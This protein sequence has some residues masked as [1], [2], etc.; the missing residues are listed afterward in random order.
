MSYVRC[1]SITDGSADTERGRGEEDGSVAGGASPPLQ[2]SN[3]R[4]GVP[5]G[6]TLT[7]EF[8]T[9]HPEGRGRRPG[10]GHEKKPSF[11]HSQSIQSRSIHSRSPT[12]SRR[13]SMVIH[14]DRGAL[15]SLRSHCESNCLAD[16]APT[17]VPLGRRNTTRQSQR[18][19]FSAQTKKTA[20]TQSYGGFPYPT[21]LLLR[22]FKKLFPSLQRRF[23]RTVTMPRAPTMTGQM[24]EP[25]NYVTFDAVVGRNSA[26]HMLTEEHLQELGGVEYRALT[27]L[28]WII[29]AVSLSWI[30]VILLTKVP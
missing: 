6:H 13:H 22:L 8:K 11:K 23:V 15:I 17:G 10:L 26:F 27:A 2:Q 3:T 18:S 4:S 1:S 19:H 14:D 5:L 24:T 29:A 9:P 21:D 20:M 12:G 30:H 25:A 7:V 16:Y 28:L